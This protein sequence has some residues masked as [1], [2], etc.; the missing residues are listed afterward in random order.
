MSDDLMKN[1][2]VLLKNE[3]VSIKECSRLTGLM[4][5]AVMNR[6]SM[7]LKGLLSQLSEEAERFR[8]IEERRLEGYSRLCRSLGFSEETSFFTLLPHLSVNY[9]EIIASHYRQLKSEVVRYQGYLK[10]LDDYVYTVTGTVNSV[11]DSY[12]QK[13][14]GGVYNQ[15]GNFYSAPQQNQSVFISTEL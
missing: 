3:V 8:L 5:T 14:S 13:K 1:F 11:L 10:N 9:K 4:K 12:V 6:D 2:E 15:S 7:A